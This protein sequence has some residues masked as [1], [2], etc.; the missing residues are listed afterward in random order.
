MTAQFN[1]IVAEH[2]IADLLRVAER[3]RIARMASREPFALVQGA[4]SA[5][6]EWAPSTITAGA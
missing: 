2:R 6:C 4:S 3:E 5:I 1:H